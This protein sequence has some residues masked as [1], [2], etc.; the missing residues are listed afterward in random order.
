ENLVAKL[1]ESTVNGAVRYRQGGV[2]ELLVDVR[3]DSIVLPPPA[4]E[5]AADYDPA[6]EYSDGR[7]I[8]DLPVPLDAM[9]KLNARVA[10]D[11]R[12]FRRDA[13]RLRNVRFRAE[14]R[15]QT[16]DVSDAGFEALSGRLDARLYVTPV[17]DKASVHLQLQARDFALGLSPT[18]RDAAMKGR[19]D[20]DLHG[21]GDNLR[22]VMADS[23]GVL[24]VDLRGGRVAKNHLFHALYG[25][26]LNE[27][28]STI[29]PFYRRDQFTPFECIV[30][31]IR[32][33]KGIAGGDP[34]TYI[35]TDKIRIN[36]KSNINLRTEKIDINVR[37]TPRQA[38]GISAGELLNPYIKVVGTLAKPRLAVDEEGVLL[39][40][41]AAVATG[42]LSVLARAAWDRVSQSGDECQK[43]A[44]EGLAALG[45]QLPVLK[46]ARSSGK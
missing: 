38:L 7:L 30:L 45:A 36:L 6:P 29:N 23:S 18:N 24:Y 8:P 43:T 35:E 10:V 4:A 33:N 14:L 20:V 28:I 12:E 44:D 22:S 46:P 21:T 27:V 11:I 2:P 26:L 41:G 42:G 3:S 19:I 16:L 17:D 25:D 5:G 40:G 1:G 13:L 31:P 39:S 34:Y 15:D 37:T 9:K 32:I